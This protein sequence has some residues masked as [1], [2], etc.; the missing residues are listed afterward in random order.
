MLGFDAFRTLGADALEIALANWRKLPADAQLPPA[1]HFFQLFLVLPSWSAGAHY[2]VDL[3]GSAVRVQSVEGAK[4]SEEPSGDSAHGASRAAS[5]S[6]VTGEGSS[7]GLEGS[8]SLA[9]SLRL[10]NAPMPWA[11]TGDPIWPAHAVSI[12]G[13]GI[14]S[15]AH[16]TCTGLHDLPPAAPP[17]PKFPKPMPPPL[18]WLRPQPPPSP[19]PQ[20]ATAPSAASILDQASLGSFKVGFFAATYAAVVLPGLLALVAILWIC[21][22]LR[23]C[24]SAATHERAGAREHPRCGKRAVSSQRMRQDADEEGGSDNES[25]FSSLMGGP[26]I[27]RPKGSNKAAADAKHAANRTA[28]SLAKELR[29]LAGQ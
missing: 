2:Q 9:I 15:A 14:V 6:D 7:D 29:K 8:S 1:R 11:G 4:L 3:H 19:P 23:R 10:H 17:P 12:A 18:A 26:P 25:E 20:L 22:G 16:V 28:K 27:R 13:W 5:S 21:V 24:R